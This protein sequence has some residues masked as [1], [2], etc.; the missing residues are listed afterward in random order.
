LSIRF[1]YIHCKDKIKFNVKMKILGLDLGTNSLGWALVNE[2]DKIILKTGVRIFQ[3]GVNIDAKSKAETPK[4]AKRREYRQKRRQLFR[5]KFRNRL[6]QKAL[7]QAGLLPFDAGALA[8]LWQT[9]PYQLRRKALNECLSLEELGRVIFHLNQRRGFKS[10]RKSAATEEGALYT[11]GNGKVGVDSTLADWQAGGFRTFG[12]YLAFLDPHQQRLR[13]RYT[14]RTWY[15]EEFNQ[16]WQ[17]QQ[18]YC[19]EVL[20]DELKQKLGSPDAGIIFYQRPLKTQ[21]HLVGK[22]T[23]EPT[24][25]RCPLS[26]PDF[27]EFRMWQIINNLAVSGP[28]RFKERLDDE[29]KTKLVDLFC[30]KDK[31]TLP[32][33]RKRLRLTIDHTF[34]YEEKEI[35]FSGNLTHVKLSKL[36]GKSIWEQL[37]D[38]D[39]TLATEKAQEK[40]VTKL[41]VW[42]T[43]FFAQDGDWLKNYATTKWDFTETQLKQLSRV[44]LKDGYASLSRKAIR[45]MLP[46]L[47]QGEPYDKAALLAGY[48]H[49]QV[50]T[51]KENQEQLGPPKNLRNPIVQQALLELRTL[52]NQLLVQYGKP[53]IIRVELARDLKVP[54]WKREEIRREQLRNRFRNE[55][56]CQE[57]VQQ[58]ILSPSSRDIEKYLLWE[59]CGKTCPYTGQAISFNDLFL[60]GR[61]DIE[62]ILPRS[63]TLDDSLANKTL[64]AKE[65]N[66]LKNN[67]TPFECLSGNQVLYLQVLERVQRYMPRK[68]GKFKLEVC[69]PDFVQK[70]LNDTRYISKEAKSYLQSI[71]PTVQVAMG[72][73]TAPLRHLWGLNS[74]LNQHGQRK[75]RDDHRHHAVDA[76]VVALSTP[77]MLQQLSRW[78][79]LDRSLN[80]FHFDLPWETFYRD[81][82]TAIE[83]VL[84]SQKKNI[85]T[86]STWNKREKK[87]GQVIIQKRVSPRGQLH[88]ETVYGKRLDGHG[89]EFFAVR[90]SLEDLSPSMVSKIVDPVVRQIVKDRLRSMGVDPDAKRFEIPKE[91]FNEPLYMPNYKGTSGRQNQIK[92]VRISEGSTKMVRLKENINQWVEPGNN[93]YLAIYS[94]HQN[95]KATVATFL[96]AVERKRQGLPLIPNTLESGHKLQ[97]FLFA[98]DMVLVGLKDEEVNWSNSKDLSQY[99]YRIQKMSIFG[100]DKNGRTKN[101]IDCVFRHHLAATI[102]DNS[103]RLVIRIPEEWEKL[104]AWEKLN[105]IKVVL[106]PMGQIRKC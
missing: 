72:R 89:R 91:A 87:N 105:P 101:Y 65:F 100:Q 85:K 74:I 52:V 63:R 54:K 58:G 50:N 84:V 10:N 15:I 90:K 64:C 92:K 29:E 41:D 73:A 9:D 23:L 55:R 31:I 20:T 69:E 82:R 6:L 32:D 40:Y 76:L 37:P 68:L 42:H 57:L 70:Q 7:Q 3:A 103:N 28:G 81:A 80:L 12:E 99:L 106:N 39:K 67:Q 61:F 38:E 27:E 79:S 5:R 83:A 51:Y 16:I 60:N 45:K 102:E 46:F 66:G 86:I 22:C 11:G 59:E 49:S 24:K 19:P 25:P 17:A 71:C 75:T 94:L 98:N 96:E 62:H 78:N 97:T 47:R 30:S 93:H 44:H 88:K 35:S 26:H 2:T 95:K 21:R 36:F 33:I 53:D 8:T 34:N 48:H 56:H 1:K 104:S 14:L 4:N 18:T 43:F 77:G 13:N